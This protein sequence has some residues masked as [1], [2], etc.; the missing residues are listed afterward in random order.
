MQTRTASPAR[1]GVIA[2]LAGV[3]LVA[4]GIAGLASCSRPAPQAGPTSRVVVISPSGQS[5]PVTPEGGPGAGT[6]PGRATRIS[7]ERGQVIAANF[8]G[9][10]GGSGQT[11]SAPTLWWRWEVPRTGTYAFTTSSSEFDTTLT[12]Y[13]G[14]PG[15]LSVVATND[16]NGDVQTSAVT[17]TVGAGESLFLAVSSKTGDT[18]LAVLAWAP[19]T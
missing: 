7:G 2:G 10:I 16:D 1:R 17:L 3:A 15:S 8:D 6:E 4:A 19:Q 9:G 13:T 18:G 5:T 11:L 14:E 12:A